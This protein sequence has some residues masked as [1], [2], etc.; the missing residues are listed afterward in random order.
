MQRTLQTKIRTP[1]ELAASN[2]IRLSWPL[3][4]GVG[5]ALLAR[6]Q[7]ANGLAPF[8][9][10]FLTAALLHPSQHLA[11]SIFMVLG[12]ASAAFCAEGFQHTALAATG[13]VVLG[14]AGLR[15]IGRWLQR[16]P[17]SATAASVLTG[18]A[19]LLPETAIAAEGTWQSARI[20]LTAVAAAAGEPFFRALLDVRPTRKH[21]MPEERIGLLIFAVAAQAGLY[22]LWPP[23]GMTAAWSAVL[24]MAG[25]GSQTAAA[26]GLSAGTALL[27]SGGSASQM[28]VLGVCGLAVGMLPQRRKWQLAVVLPFA[29]ATGVF[30]LN[31]SYIDALCTLA[32]DALFL[33][34]PE[35]LL[36]HIRMWIEGDR[37]SACDPDRLA[38][39]LRAESERK[40]RALSAAFGEMAERYR[41]PIEVPDEQSLIAEMRSA[42]CEGCSNYAEC[43][44]GDDNRAVRFLCQLISAAIEWAN[45]APGEPLFHDEMPPDVLRICR[46]GRAVPTRL[47]VLLEEFAQKRKTELKRGAT[48]QL[49]SAQFM[50]AQMLLCGMADKQSEPVRIRGQQ[51]A[52]ARAALDRAGVEVRDV[53]ALRGA[54]QMEIIATLKTGRWSPQLAAQASLQLSRV[55]GRNYVP[56]ESCG[57]TEMKFIR[58]AQLRATA[59]AATRA[60]TKGVACGDFAL[61]R[62]LDGDRL[63][64]MLCDGM[65]S[66]EDAARESAQTA[67]LLSE[68]LAAG[69]SEELALETV[70]ELMLARSDT[71]MFATVDFCVIDLNSGEARFSKLAASKS[72]IVR[73]EG[74][75]EVEGGR[76]PLGIL[77]KVRPERQIV[78]LRAGDVVV[79]ATDGVMDG[80]DAQPLNDCLHKGLHM[81][82]QMLANALLDAAAQARYPDDATALVARITLRPQSKTA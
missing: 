15:L 56:G 33:A 27:M 2:A 4:M 51:A 31:I 52:R 13:I 8:A 62:M 59:A 58:Q 70:N 19:V 53:M 46:R 41:L 75:I 14:A 48:H 7:T 80:I 37:F 69:V 20:L 77:E 5:T 65:G 82:P 39:R 22:A 38:V 64:L 11:A 54:R 66:G 71:D 60:R 10:A 36:Q 17:Q 1:K 16:I 32:A 42:L 57:M 43:W 30:L 72:M 78:R 23:L 35:H 28:A 25:A 26:T 9:L 67:R 6:A 81:P 49:I 55:F 74:I 76:L 79:M 34:A 73:K 24:I 29:A 12:A 50:Q 68:F 47:G 18:L 3:A 45:A 21:L 40:L 63:L 44:A 61:T